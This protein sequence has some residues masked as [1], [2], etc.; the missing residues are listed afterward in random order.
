M[1]FSTRSG[2]ACWDSRSV[3]RYR[4]RSSIS[5]GKCVAPSRSSP[6][7]PRWERLTCSARTKFRARAPCCKRWGFIE[8]P[9]SPS[10]LVNSSIVDHLD[11]HRVGRLP[12]VTVGAHQLIDWV[13]GSD[14]HRP[15][16]ARFEDRPAVAPDFGP[17][18]ACHAG[19]RA[20]QFAKLDDGFV[21]RKDFPLV[22]LAN[23][24]AFPRHVILGPCRRGPEFH[25][26][27]VALDRLDAVGHD[28]NGRPDSTRFRGLFRR[29]MQKQVS[30]EGNGRAGEGEGQRGPKG[31]RIGE[32]HSEEA[33]AVVLLPLLGHARKC[34]G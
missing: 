16:P 29:R 17:A 11:E 5:A 21:A 31:F 23:A 8:P 10:R 25:P 4:T 30:D 28:H 13:I 19:I 26:P 14:G 22:P 24:A 34:R 1:S 2:C 15:P 20:E 6:C 32:A 3:T 33:C 27:H 18:I 12:K 7:W 9:T